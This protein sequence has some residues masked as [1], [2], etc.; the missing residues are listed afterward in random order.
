VL[1]PKGK[2]QCR[3]LKA[4]FAHH[5]TVDAVFAS[6]LRRT[7]QTA[8]LSFGP[9][10]TRKEVPFILIPGLQELGATGSDTGL[11]N[12]AADLKQ[13]L[14]DLFA[15]GELEFDLAKIDASAVTAGWN[16]KVPQHQSLRS[17]SQRGYWAYEK[18][19]ISKRAAD[20]RNW[21]FQRPE[22]EVILVTHG[23]IA[24]FLTEDWDV[25]DPMLGT[26][27]LNCWCTSSRL[28]LSQ[29][30][31]LRRTPRVR[32]HA[33]VDCDGCARN[34]GPRQPESDPHVVEELQAM[35]KDADKS[36]NS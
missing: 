13:L 4:A 7:I 12:T 35:Q 10:L 21:L 1:T 30:T 19:A 3:A 23:A 8:S 14:P 17:T 24:H 5:Q 25:E 29:L 18:E 2:E 34:R 9:T 36:S 22:K 27:Y 28:A 16:S 31:L 33:R 26:A 20:V 15:E 11:A 32:L 6:P